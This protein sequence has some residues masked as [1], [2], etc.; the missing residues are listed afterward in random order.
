[1]TTDGN[2]VSGRGAEAAASGTAALAGSDGPGET[3]LAELAGA[4]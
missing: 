1:M 2:R 3:A 4:S